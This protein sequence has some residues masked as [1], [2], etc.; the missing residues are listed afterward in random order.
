MKIILPKL[1]LL[2]L[3]MAFISCSDDDDGNGSGSPSGSD[4][5][6]ALVIDN[7]SQTIK[8]GSQ[9]KYSAK[10]IDQD[11]NANSAS[12]IS[13]KTSDNEIATISGSG[14]LNAIASGAITITAETIIDGANLSTSVVLSVLD[15]SPAF[16]V[17]PGAIAWF[18]DEGDIPLTIVYLGT[19]NASYTYSSS[20]ESI[21]KV[22]ATGVVSF[23]NPGNC[24]LMVRSSIGGNP[25]VQVPVLVIGTP[26]APLP[27][28]RVEI[29]NKNNE[30]TLNHQMFRNQSERFSAKAFNKDGVE[31]NADFVWSVADDTLATVSQNGKL[32]SLDKIGRTLVQATASGIKGQAEIF[33][34]P[35]SVIVVTPPFKQNVLA[36]T[37][38]QLSA[39]LYKFN[40]STLSLDPSPIQSPAQGVKWEVL[41][42]K[43]DPLNPGI[44]LAPATVSSNGLV[45]L[46]SDVILGDFIFIAA[47]IP[48]TKSDPGG[49]FFI[50]GF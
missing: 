16:G 38:H 47:T 7:G 4:K 45:T 9:I 1:A 44:P 27:I 36:G 15:E 37:T 31:V 24:I 32:N 50:V 39:D 12:G 42:T 14:T 28:S 22:S 23:L 11:G 34:Y 43:I 25:T 8:I 33:I 18:P 49:A 35:D 48:G 46:N 5:N 3:I 17:V 30:K 13:W 10:I 2:I 21:A 29:F 26:T 6:S 19:E 20:D 41:R 40:P